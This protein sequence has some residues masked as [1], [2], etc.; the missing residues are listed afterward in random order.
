MKENHNLSGKKKR[1][2]NM[3]TQ[4]SNLTVMAL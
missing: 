2:M 1:A 4:E 3:T